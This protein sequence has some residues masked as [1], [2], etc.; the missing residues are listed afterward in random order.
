MSI[1]VSVKINDGIVM[2]AD[3]ATT[4]MKNTGETIQRYEHANKIVNLVKGLP[5]GVMTCG[6]GG[7]GTASIDTLLKDLRIRLSRNGVA[8]ID[9]N[10]YTL[11]QVSSLVREFFEE[12]AK[13]VDF[14]NYLILR[15]CGYSSNHSLAEVW[16]IG[17]NDG[18]IFGPFVVQK[19]E[20][21]GPRWNRELEALDRLI[22]GV[23]SSLSEAIVNEGIL[24]KE[25]LDAG[26][27]KACAHLIEPLIMHAAPIQ[28]AI[29]LARFLVETTEGFFRFSIKR[30]KTVGGAVEIAAITKHEGFKWVRRKHFYSRELNPE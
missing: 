13:A 11:E 23:S 15:I 9:P 21:M 16:Q 25:Q 30:A 20:D 7:I 2:A 1:I 4:F 6:S 24:T 19:E 28:D 22:I 12:K 27:S 17:F 5:I 3:S 18:Q 14:N 8:A 10:N 29:D 26:W